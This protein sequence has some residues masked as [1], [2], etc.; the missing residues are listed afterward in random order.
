MRYFTN[1]VYEK[2]MLQIPRP[3]CKSRI[4]PAPKGHFCHGCKRYGEACI[5][6]CYRDTQ[7][8][9]RKEVILCSL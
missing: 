2:M 3:T 7:F 8:Q 6:P 9:T 4:S 5:R 1:S